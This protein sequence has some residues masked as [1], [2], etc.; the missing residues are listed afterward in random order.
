[1]N[2]E[3]DNKTEYLH[4]N[5]LC[6]GGGIAYG[7]QSINSYVNCYDCQDYNQY[8]AKMGSYNCIESNSISNEGVNGVVN[9]MLAKLYDTDGMQSHVLWYNMSGDHSKVS[10]GVYQAMNVG[11]RKTVVA[12]FLNKRKYKGQWVDIVHVNGQEVGIKGYYYLMPDGDTFTYNL[13]CCGH[14]P[15]GYLQVIASINCHIL[16]IPVDMNQSLIDVKTGQ[17]WHMTTIARI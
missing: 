16:K 13:T 5:E 11:N 9:K 4:N 8:F 10:D 12:M 1:M 7:N 15:Q 14:P 3:T 2:D 6:F 17:N